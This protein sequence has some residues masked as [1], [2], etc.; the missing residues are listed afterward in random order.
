MVVVKEM[1]ESE[2]IYE[3]EVFSMVTLVVFS[4]CVGSE[5]SRCTLELEACQ[6]GNRK[7]AW[8]L[9]SVSGPYEHHLL[10]KTILVGSDRTQIYT[11]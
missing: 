8:I 6:R 11:A 3:E 2:Y 10:V 4:K 7:I 1:W 9:N 5:D